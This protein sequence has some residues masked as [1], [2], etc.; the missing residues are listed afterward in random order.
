MNKN[1][2]ILVVDDDKASRL[3]LKYFINRFGYTTILAHDG[4]TALDLIKN[5][6][7]DLILLD[8]LMPKKDGYDVL[9]AIRNN[10]KWRHIPVVMITAVDEFSSVVKCIKDGAV[11]YLPKPI[12]KTLLEARIVSCLE[13]K[14]WHDYE[15]RLYTE[16]IKKY[17]D[18]KEYEEH[19][20]HL[21]Q[22]IDQSS[23]PIVITDYNGKIEYVNKLFLSRTGY[24]REEV[25]GENPK[26][27]KSDLHP[28][29]FYANLWAEITAGKDWHGRFYNKKKNGDFYWEYQYISPVKNNDG[30]I[31]HFVAVKIDDTEHVMTEN[32]AKQNEEKF[33]RIL[34][35]SE[36]AIVSIDE[37]YKI[38]LFNKMAENV[39]GYTPDEIIGK[40]INTLLP[41]RFRANHC[42]HI[43]NFA[44]SKISAK[45]LNERF[46][47][48][49]GL[50]KNGEEFPAEISISQTKED[51]KLIFTALVHDISKQ[52]KMEDKVLRAQRIESI[53]AIA[54]GI[55]HDFN[56][57]LTV[58]L[59]N[60]NLAMLFAKAGNAEKALETLAKIEKATVRSSNLTQQLISFSKSGSSVTG[61]LSASKLVKDTIEFAIKGTNI[62]CEFFIPDDLWYIDVDETQLNQVLNNMVIN[63]SHAMPEGGSIKVEAQNISTIPKELLSSL[64]QGK[65]IQISITDYGVG[66]KREHLTNI[67][68]A[69]F[70]TKANGNG[71]G[72]STS[73]T[74]IKKHNGLITVMSELGKG[75]TF[76]IYL[77]ASFNNIPIKNEED[78]TSSLK[79][80]GKIL[81]MDDDD[82]IRDVGSRTLG[83]IGYNVESVKDG[84]EAIEM[85]KRSIAEGKPFDVVIMDLKVHGGMGGKEAVEKLH[86]IAPEAKTVASGGFPNDPIIVNYQEYGFNGAMCKPFEFKE[87][88]KLLQKIINE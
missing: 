69:Y 63:A 64:S 57:I 35:I 6:P 19:S 43:D 81:I 75:T 46:Y 48:L 7:P 25:I 70:T 31:T 59:G 54:S 32:I 88:N 66:I 5:L 20:H 13:K 14:Q 33:N 68:N 36:D 51:G 78:V 53:G 34:D 76:H 45:R 65:Y 12:N 67:F 10:E 3:L 4:E 26:I 40:H 2:K 52:A 8:I 85:Y 58:I 21:S 38:M 9:R 47:K 29:E 42:S 80:D 17:N 72:L 61:I 56:N 22:A 23:A 11:D 71:L 44:L 83:Y 84:V 1:I 15:Q 28:D 41:E 16:I 18:L 27:L 37:E 74:I 49:F 73:Y 87:L 79:G 82:E 50:Q 86:E 77:P 39:F 62:G 24:S 30:D 60:T 55:A